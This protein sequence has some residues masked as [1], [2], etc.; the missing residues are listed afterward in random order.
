MRARSC[1][2]G[3]SSTLVIIFPRCAGVRRLR[4]W[5]A[6]GPSLSYDAVTGQGCF[7]ALGLPRRPALQARYV[8]LGDSPR[9]P[10]LPH[11]RELAPLDGTT[12]PGRAL[13]E[14]RR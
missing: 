12:D 8:G 9:P 6:M 4:G 14:A 11:A 13:L 7:V 1:R 3:G 10:E 2:S 5:A